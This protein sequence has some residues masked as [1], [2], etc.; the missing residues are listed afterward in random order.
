MRQWSS[1]SARKVLKAIL[2]KGWTIKRQNGSHRRLE[3]PDYPDYTFAFHDSEEIG[4]KMLA[5]IA[6]STGI[7]PDDL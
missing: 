1:T 7:M 6:E 2:R 5:K 4:P 3:H